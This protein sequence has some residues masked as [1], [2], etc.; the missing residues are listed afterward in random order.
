MP[1]AWEK[2]LED[3]PFDV[4]PKPTTT[5]MHRN[6]K[7]SIYP[8]CEMCGTREEVTFAPDPYRSEIC[9]DDAPRHLCPGCRAAQAE[10][11]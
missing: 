4:E 1:N 5:K 3:E 10:E 9:G 8:K 11:I 7:N 2:I 6:K